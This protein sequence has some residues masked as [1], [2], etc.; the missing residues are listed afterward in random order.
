VKKTDYLRNNLM[1]ETLRGMVSEIEGKEKTLRTTLLMT[2]GQDMGS[3]IALA[4]SKLPFHP[5]AA[6]PNSLLKAAYSNNPDIAKVEAGVR[7]A[8]FGLKAARSGHMPK[9]AL[10]GKA[11]QIWNSFDSGLV[12]PENKS[13]WMLGLG[14]DIPIFQ[15]FRVVHEVAEQKASLRK[16]QHQR[17]LLRDGIA[18]QVRS[19]CFDLLKTEEKQ[20]STQ[21]ALLSA[22]ENR[23]L[24]VRAYQEELVETKEVIEAQIIEALLSAQYQQVLYEYLEIQ[25]KLEFLVGRGKTEAE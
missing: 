24:N 2:M 18:L 3:A 5:D 22:Q 14:V 10:V 4:D 9:V 8:E 25:A 23:E 1:V 21:K 6:D 15:G 11:S 13:S 19:A 12:T 16:L 20:E 7:A 17:D